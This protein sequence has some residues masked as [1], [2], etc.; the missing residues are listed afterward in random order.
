MCRLYIF[1]S[2]GASFVHISIIRGSWREIFMLGAQTFS[3]FVE[4]K[5]PRERQK[6]GDSHRICMITGVA[7]N[8]RNA[9]GKDIKKLGAVYEESDVSMYI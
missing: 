4:V 8:E 6:R 9:L 2:L 3:V 7:Q 5:M 1:R